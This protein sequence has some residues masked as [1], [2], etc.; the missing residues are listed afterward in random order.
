MRIRRVFAL[1]PLTLLAPACA[2]APGAARPAAFPGAPVI[3]RPAPLPNPPSEP[4]DVPRLTQAALALRGTPYQPGGEAPATGFD[5]SGFVRYLFRDQGWELPRTVRQQWDY[6][7]RIRE[8]EIQAGDLLFFQT[9]SRGA[10][11]VGIVID[12]PSERSGRAFIHAPGENGTVRIDVLV[13][14]YWRSRFIGA[15]RLF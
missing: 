11:H 14:P 12:A 13:T 2:A 8:S 6:G 7:R 10:S 3:S 1:V 9:E 5:C 4:L 15:R